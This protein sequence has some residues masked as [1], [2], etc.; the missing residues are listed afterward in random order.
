VTVVDA[1]LARV[2]RLGTADPGC[3][4]AADQRRDRGG[5]PLAVRTVDHHVSAVLTKLG[6]I[7]RREAVAAARRC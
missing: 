1:V 6:V 7:T 3:A 4:G 2:D 5:P